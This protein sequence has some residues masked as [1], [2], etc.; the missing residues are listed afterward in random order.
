MFPVDGC[1]GRNRL[2][3]KQDVV[4]ECEMS[5]PRVEPFSFQG[6]KDP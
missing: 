1:L 4:S 6:Q 2:G 3:R 5:S